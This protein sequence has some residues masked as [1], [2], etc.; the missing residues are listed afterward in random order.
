MDKFIA[1]G[2]KKADFIQINKTETN[3]RTVEVSDSKLNNATEE[4]EIKY[5]VRVWVDKKASLVYSNNL[6]NDLIDK[7]VKIA[8]A[9]KKDESFYGLPNNKKMTNVK[10]LF[11]KK[12]QDFS[13]EDAINKMNGFLKNI[14]DV[15]IAESHFRV[16]DGSI[17]IAGSEGV[18]F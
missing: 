16:M 13:G 2:K 5:F 11:S 10:G 3:M 4:K 14:K 15:T 17:K 7:A 1:Y 9:S 8:K 6:S 12:V 18:D